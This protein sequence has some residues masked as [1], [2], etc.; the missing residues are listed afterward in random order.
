MCVSQFFTSKDFKSK[1]CRQLHLSTKLIKTL[2]I[3]YVLNGYEKHVLISIV[4][5]NGYNYV[6]YTG[7]CQQIRQLL[8]EILRHPGYHNHSALLIYV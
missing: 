3:G 8:R 4:V 2:K 7:F 6:G 5:S 1:L